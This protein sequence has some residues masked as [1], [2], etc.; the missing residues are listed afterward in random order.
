MTQESYSAAGVMGGAKSLNISHPAD[1][2][3][4]KRSDEHVVKLNVAVAQNIPVE[5][6]EIYGLKNEVQ[7]QTYTHFTS[8]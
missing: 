4:D 6:L 3:P 8:P 7:S 1:N 5:V 2:I